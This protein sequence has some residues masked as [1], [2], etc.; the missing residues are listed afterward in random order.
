MDNIESFFALIRVGLW[1]KTQKV[2]YYSQKDFYSAEL[3]AVRKGQTDGLKVYSFS[4]TNLQSRLNALPASFD[5]EEILR[6]AEEQSVVGLLTAGIQIAGVHVPL[7]QKLKFFGECQLVEQRNA[8]MNCFLEELVPRLIEAGINAVLVKGQGIAQCYAK[9]QWRSCGDVDLLLDIDGFGTAKRLL[10][11]MASDAGKEFEY[12]RHQALSIGPWTV[13]LHG[14]QR[15]GLSTKIDAVIDEVQK[16]VF[17]EYDVRYWRNGNVIVP[18]PGANSDVI[19]IFTHFLKHFYKGG[20]GL[21]QICDWCRLLWTYRESIDKQMVESRIKRMGLMSE[22]RAFAAFAVY[23]LGM[24]VEAMPLFDDTPKWNRKAER[25]KNFV[26]RVGSFGKNRDMSYYG[27]Y[28]YLVRKCISMS[29]RVRDL[30]CHSRIFPLDSLRFFP[31]IIF[32]GLRSAM[33]GE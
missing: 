1:E 33:R 8:A 9:P 4:V 17:E 25:I 2:N 18:L 24:P 20:L 3:N 23:Y 11:P 31:R 26:M 32:N 28:P 16:T 7:D 10:M 29:Y 19:L 14:S 30:V 6:F 15:C 27:E 12:E 22:W 5:Y 21:K 13:E